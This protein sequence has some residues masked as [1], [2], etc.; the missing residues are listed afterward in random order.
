MTTSQILYYK[1]NVTIVRRC[2]I[3]EEWEIDEKVGDMV[4]EKVSDMVVDMV[5]EMVGEKVGDVVCEKAGE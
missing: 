2:V 3:L 4:G 5:G 1:L